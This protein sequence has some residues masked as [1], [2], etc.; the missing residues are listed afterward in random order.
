MEQV[1]YTDAQLK[2]AENKFEKVIGTF[3]SPI[4][5]D[6]LVAQIKKLEVEIGIAA[7]D[8]DVEFLNLLR[9]QRENT[10]NFAEKIRNLVLKHP[11]YPLFSSQEKAEILFGHIWGG[12]AQ[13]ALGL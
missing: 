8:E 11:S 10:S 2:S 3:L 6:G 13:A 5:L 7:C 9:V 1:K 12:K 4:I